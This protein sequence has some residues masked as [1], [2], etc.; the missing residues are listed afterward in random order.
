MALLLSAICL[1]CL[2]GMGYVLGRQRALAV[3][4]LARRQMHSLPEHHGALV[5]VCAAIPAFAVLV[6]GA[7]ASA[8]SLPV[9]AAAIAA[10]TLGGGLAR[11][12]IR[13]AARART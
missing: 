10:G 5:A 3:A 2:I 4:G 11:R 13:P 7:L 6:I 12:S 8:G 1:L 9:L